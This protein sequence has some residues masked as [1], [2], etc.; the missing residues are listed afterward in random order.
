MIKITF[1]RHLKTQG[2][3]EKRYIGKTDE[4]LFEATKQSILT[5]LPEAELLFSSPMQRC[6]ETAGLIFPYV[7]PIIIENL[8]EIDFGDFE[9]KC[10][11]ELK[12]NQDYIKFIDSN[13]NGIIPNGENTVDFK[14]RCCEAFLQIVK[15]LEEYKKT[16][17][18][19]V[20]HGGT[21]MSI[22]E[23]FEEE[24]KSFY[25]YQV[26]NGAG[27]E[28]EFNLETKKIKLIKELV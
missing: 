7:E 10:Y 5:T 1:I 13:G 24:S 23:H 6:R 20:C 16:S 3:Y 25:D 19:V 11:E 26:K 21:I 15:L 2:N 12:D 4:S 28:T 14:I 8:N 17:A 18:I 9:N 22:L 27:F